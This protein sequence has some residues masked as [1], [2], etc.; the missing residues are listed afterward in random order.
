MGLMLD[1][2][3]QV[4]KSLQLRRQVVGSWTLS[5]PFTRNIKGPRA[6]EKNTS[7]NLEKFKWAPNQGE[8][9]KSCC[10]IFICV[11]LPS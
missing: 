3:A 1:L 11:F 2:M 10:Y 7:T 5:H 6:C 9:V 4:A 8:L